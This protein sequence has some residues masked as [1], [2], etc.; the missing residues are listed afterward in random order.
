MVELNRV[1]SISVVFIFHLRDASGLARML[2]FLSS[3]N[4]RLEDQG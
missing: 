2:A 3:Y 4:R 1:R